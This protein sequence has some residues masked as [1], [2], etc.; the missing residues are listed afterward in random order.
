M[1]KQTIIGILGPTASGKTKYAVE[2]AYKL[3]AEIISMDSRQVYKGLNIGA[4][5]DLQEYTIQGKEIPYHLIDIVD[6]N[7]PYHIHQFK[8]DFHKAFQSIISRG[9]QVIAC[10]GTGLYFDV[11]LNDR[12]LTAVPV[13]EA[14]RLELDKLTH[15]ELLRIIQLENTTFQVFDTSTKKRC[16]RAVEII[17]FLKNNSLPESDSP[18][19]NWELQCLDIDVAERNKRI[20]E[21]L[22]RRVEE[23][24]FE[25]VENLIKS[26]I[27][28]DRLIYLGLEYKFITQYFLG[29]YSKEEC[30]EKLKI[31]I[32]QFAKRQMTFFRKI[33]KN[34][35][36][37]MRHRT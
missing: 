7:T 14:L 12:S 30:I 3:D 13:D 33:E 37:D 15:E 18:K 31:A 22:Y 5:K 9:K 27:S 4:G 23:G 2:L 36:I 17:K 26:G 19:Y 10:G 35:M 24:L 6:I 25:E 32:H 20:D 8:L 11:L 29:Q 16:I 28:A 34:H 21:R 1:D